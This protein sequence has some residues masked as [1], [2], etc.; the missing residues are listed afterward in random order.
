M[1]L[2]ASR[3][4]PWGGETLLLQLLLKLCCLGSDFSEG[5]GEEHVMKSREPTLR[6]AVYSTGAYNSLNFLSVRFHLIGWAIFGL[7]TEFQMVGFLL[8]QRGKTSLQ[9]LQRLTL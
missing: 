4:R 8:L 3:R 5:T 6:H 7:T 1:T 2:A 9:R